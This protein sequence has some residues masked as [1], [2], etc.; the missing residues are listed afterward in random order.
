[1]GMD[2]S[3]H[4][5]YGIPAAVT[6]GSNVA[7]F[8]AGGVA[9]PTIGIIED[10]DFPGG[11]STLGLLQ[12]A[13]FTNLTEISPANLATTDLSQFQE[14]WFGPTDN[15]ND[16]NYYIAAESEIQDYLQGGGGLVVEAELYAANSFSWV[17]YASLI[18]SSGGNPNAVTDVQDVSIVDPSSPIMAGLSSGNWQQTAGGQ[19]L[20]GW[21]SSVHSD[22]STPSAAGFTTLVTDSQG[23]AVVMAMVFNPN[24]A[25]TQIE[26]QLPATGYNVDPS[27]ISPGA[28][29]VSASGVV[30]NA[31]VVGGFTDSQFQLTGTVANMTPGEVEQIS[32]GITVTETTTTSTGQ[33]LVETIT[34][35]P[36]T[37]AAEHIISLTPPAQTANTSTTADYTVALTN[38]LSTDE[39]Y[40]LSV[41]GLSG[42]TVGLAASMLMPAGQT[43]DVPL[44]VTVPAGAAAGTQVFEV[45]TT[46]AAGA[47]DSVEGQLTVTS[48]V[49]LP[50]VNV[51]LSPSSATAGQGTSASY[52]V[53]V[54][55]VGNATDTYNLAVMGLP[56]GIAA[57]F[58]PATITAPPGQS[59]FRDVTLTLTP[60]P[61]TAAADY[62]FTVT[63]VST[64][65]SAATATTQGTLT[66]AANGV[67]VSL[68][69]GSAAPGTTFQMT[70]TNTGTASD[71]Y[72]LALTGPAAVV[73]TLAV[74]QVTLAPGAS[75]MVSITTSAVNFADP[76]GLALTAMATSQTN[77]AVGAAATATLSIPS[78]EGLTAQFNPS[79]QVVP[80]PGSSS[81]ILLVNN[82]GNSQDS[83][84]ATIM[85][86]TGPVT[87]TL[88]GLDG[89]PTQT[90]PTFILP[91]FSTG[92]IM[93][94]ISLSSV[95]QGTVTVQVNSL[96]QPNESASV[97]ATVKTGPTPTWSRLS[98]PFIT[99]GTASV[100]LSGEIAGPGSTIPSGDVT[101]TLDGVT[102]TAAID[103]STG[104]FSANFN[105]A[106]LGVAAS[107]YTISYNFA[108]DAN[109]TASSSTATLTVTQATPAVT[110][111]TPAGITYGTA[112]GSAQLDATA[113]VAGTFVYSPAV[114]TVPNGGQGQTLSVLFTPTDSADYTTA[115]DSVTINV[116]PAQ[117]AFSVLSAPTITYG[118]ASVNLSGQIAA[119]GSLIPSGDVSITLDGVTETAPIDTSTG[120]F[121]A[122]FNTAALGVAASPYTISYSFAGNADFA[123]AG[124]TTMLTVNKATPAVTWATPADIAYGTSLG[125]TQLDATASVGG[126][127]AYSPAV[128]T[129]PNVGQGQTL[130][131][132]FTP[133]DSADY[134]TA[135]DSVTINVV[136]A[137]PAFSVL[138]VPT[139]S[140]GTPSVTLSGQ[141]VAP[142]S[143]IP[144]G[145]VS[146]TL[147]GVTATVPIDT[148]TGDFS[149]KFNTASLGAA[150]SPYTISYSVVG[151][152]DFMSASSSATLTVKKATPTVTWATPGGI[153]SGTPLGSAQLDATAGV[154][155]TFVYTPAAGTIL[156]VGQNQP[157]SVLF[158][159]ADAADY[160]TTGATTTIAVTQAPT[161]PVTITALKVE[162][163]KLGRKFHKQRALVLFV[164]FSGALDATA[165]QNLAAY[166]VFSGKKKK[167]HK[168][169]RIIY[170]KLVPLTQAIYNPSSDS[171]IL[172]PRGKHRLPK[173]EQLLVNVSLLTDPLGRPINN[174]KDFTATVANTGLVIS[175]TASAA[176]IE[177]P[178]AAAID[179]LFEHGL[180]PAVKDYSD[181]Q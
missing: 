92:A 65:S 109:F 86:T 57:S 160:T 114:G 6:L 41:S 98:V 113:S 83:Y 61:G 155:G 15:A 127:F 120:D 4:W 34:L 143:K 177:A 51:S 161:S 116:T 142:G 27:S 54:T 76:G 36:V 16:I 38:P 178:T 151:N 45:D 7:Q 135:P 95:G 3:T 12:H 81:F 67:S 87:A 129:V 123:A 169:S 62:P 55:N 10:G 24:T 103:P 137:Q 35:P 75:Q 32:T 79:V 117:P 85:G 128:G 78:T 181:G 47:S 63:A 176:A 93:L 180:M 31:N 82:T 90:I 158:R 130:S 1:M 72:T 118:T 37:V 122:N 138:S 168:V 26:D 18:G 153:T 73:S 59:N 14:L 13:G 91:G 9:N 2:P 56:A 106:A 119:P 66:V 175:P 125:S 39:T 25:Q 43:V 156:P 115:P 147:A 111:A 104:D 94:E 172:L 146:I 148:T 21:N 5:I 179:S 110:W 20:S 96:T 11:P 64:T 97:T 50:G 8:A 49:A 48:T 132:L 140:Y 107:P 162:K 126:A 84:A 167:V 29:S 144:S 53:T 99:Y 71:T 69:P 17:P 102:A 131:V 19:G 164:Q 46:D 101:I 124:S 33:P 52:T 121:S 174:G 60:A 22:F 152:A 154:A 108:G 42:F 173:F 134:T 133:T 166:T 80:V 149:A 112:L 28:T 105:T 30:W 170:N 89:L 136:A 163:V 157:L 145:N 100:T 171:V 68:D 74:S 58:S 88:M 150:G 139:I 165:A 44:E 77:P 70:V 23:N 40:N 159:P 141:I